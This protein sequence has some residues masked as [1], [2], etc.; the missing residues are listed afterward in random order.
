MKSSDIAL[1]KTIKLFVYGDPGSGK[2]TLC[3]SACDLPVEGGVMLLNIGGNPQSLRRN[4]KRPT[5]IDLD[6]TKDLNPIYSW[7]EA[8]QPKSHVFVG[9]AERAGITLTPP[10]H[11]VCCDTTTDLQRLV[12][13]ER[14]GTQDKRPGEDLKK[15]EIQ[16][17][18]EVLSITGLIV[19]RF[20]KLPLNVIFTAQERIDKDEFTGIMSYQPGLWGQ[21]RSEAPA[22]SLLTG[23]M[24]RL[25]R[26]PLKQRNELDGD[27]HSVI[28]FDAI[29][30]FLAKDQYGTVP[31][32]MA[33]PTFTKIWQSVY[34]EPT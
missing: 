33:D 9:L 23:R 15:A 25:N 32:V 31:K 14:L 18:G 12:L 20:Y 11:T 8:G 10:Y 16:H 24:M 26:V 1:D 21:S 22:Y 34:T 30:Q 27:T 7:L 13:S 5:I 29:G 2:T 4:A 28:A 6:G 19:R 17:W 3:G